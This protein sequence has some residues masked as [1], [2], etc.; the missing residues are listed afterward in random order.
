MLWFV[1]CGMFNQAIKKI[2]SV[3]ILCISYGV[4]K[5]F[6]CRWTNVFFFVIQ[7][8]LDPIQIQNNPKADHLIFRFDGHG[9]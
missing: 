7:G 1:I 3:C 2:V 9:S 6:R 8:K 4:F 5:I